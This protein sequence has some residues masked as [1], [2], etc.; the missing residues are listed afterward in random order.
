MQNAIDFCQFVSVLAL[1]AAIG[2]AVFYP[3]N[4]RLPVWLP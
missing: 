4:D 1:L 2:L 3:V